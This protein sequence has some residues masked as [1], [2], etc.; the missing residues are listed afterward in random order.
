MPNEKPPNQPKSKEEMERKCTNCDGTGKK[1]YPG[2]KHE[3]DCPT[4]RGTGFTL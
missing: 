1:N 4:C 3:V 2:G